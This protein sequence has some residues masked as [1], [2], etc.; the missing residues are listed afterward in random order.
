MSEIATNITQIYPEGIQTSSYV[1]TT[2]TIPPRFA[3]VGPVDEYWW[4]ASGPLTEEQLAIQLAG[5]VDP[6]K[7]LSPEEK[8]ILEDEAAMGYA[9]G[10]DEIKF[11]GDYPGGSDR[12]AFNLARLVLGG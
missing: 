4:G 3:L 2:D 1:F 6:S 10:A 9:V 11:T 12:I 5:D 8:V 7:R